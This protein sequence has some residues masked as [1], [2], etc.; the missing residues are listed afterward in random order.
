MLHVTNS[1]I[2]IN[3]VRRSDKARLHSKKFVIVLRHLFLANNTKTSPLAIK[4][5]SPIVIGGISSIALKLK[6][7]D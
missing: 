1:G 6:A 7:K 4:I 2:L 5:S 3:P